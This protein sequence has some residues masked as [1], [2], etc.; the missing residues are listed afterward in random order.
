MGRLAHQIRSISQRSAGTAELRQKLPFFR[1][2]F[3]K[4]ILFEPVLRVW[5]SVEAITKKDHPLIL[6][7]LRYSKTDQKN[8]YFSKKYGIV[9]IGLKIFGKNIFDFF[10]IFQ[11]LWVYGFCEVEIFDHRLILIQMSVRE[12]KIKFKWHLL[13]SFFMHFLMFLVIMKLQSSF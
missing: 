9:N 2:F 4:N 1:N 3:R 10:L 7:K 11:K 13:G 8:I 12:P 6:T 5:L